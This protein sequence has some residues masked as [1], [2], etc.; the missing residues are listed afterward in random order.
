MKTTL[1]D[2]AR[3]L[4]ISTAAASRA[5]NDLPG[6]SSEL[7]M[8]V[9]ST[10]Q[11]MGYAKYLKAS[12][13]NAYQRS[14]KFIAVVHGP[15]GGHIIHE[16]H[17]SID[18]TI[19]Q[20][21]FNELR[22]MIDTSRELQSEQAKEQFFIKLAEERGVVGILSCYL[23]LSDVLIS[24]L[25][26]RK[27]PVVLIDNT[28]EFGRC[29]SIDHVKASYRAVARLVELG[30]RHIG[31]IIPPEDAAQTWQDRHEGYRQAL[32]D[33][34]LRYDPALVMYPD[35]VGIKAG[36]LTTKALLEQSPSVDAILYASDTLAAGGL[37]MLRD[38]GKRVPEDVAVI[39]FDDEQFDVALQPTLST[40]RQPIRRMAETALQ[41]LLESIEKDD[42]SHR[43]VT[44]DTEL[45]LRGSCCAN[46][47][48]AQWL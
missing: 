38:L 2:I 4:N 48:D 24:K 11:R 31:C 28:T 36:G 26:R 16:I 33:K 21:G 41:L 43:A 22:Y 35:W 19:R 23:R 32:K 14:M 7:R 42:F 27:V 10:A 20:H 13:L 3:E 47:D 34:G 17:Q 12:M 39:G 9:K 5:L 40:V 25:N 30:R 15:V 18:E 1:K 8:K 46:A 44:F 37:R 6:V 29:V 45:V